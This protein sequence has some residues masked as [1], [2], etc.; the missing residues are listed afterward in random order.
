MF[1][2]SYGGGGVPDVGAV[3]VETAS[4]EG[5]SLYCGL[6][7]NQSDGN[8]GSWSVSKGRIVPFGFPMGYAMRMVFRRC[9]RGFY[10][11]DGVYK[12]SLELPVHPCGG[13]EGFWAGA[14]G[15]LGGCVF[16]NGYFGC[17]VN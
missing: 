13:L 4:Y 6:R 12:L 11:C 10:V 1:S 9:L 14:D 15:F 2:S 3:L 17:C 16:G 8:C 7:L 5:G